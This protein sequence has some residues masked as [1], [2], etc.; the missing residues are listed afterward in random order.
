MRGGEGAGGGFKERNRVVGRTDFDERFVRKITV[1]NILN[2]AFCKVDVDVSAL[3][4]ELDY[5]RVGLF[6]IT[7]N[8]FLQLLRGSL[9]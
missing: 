9:C 1:H 6:S 2:I 8:S 5:Y 3:L 4:I 7:R